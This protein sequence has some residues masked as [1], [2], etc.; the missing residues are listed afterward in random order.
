MLLLS[1]KNIQE[2]T[3]SHNESLN[4][5]VLQI[6]GNEKSILIF[7][8]LHHDFIEYNI[9][10]IGE[11]DIQLFL[12]DENSLCSKIVEDRVHDALGKVELLSEQDFTVFPEN[13]LIQYRSNHTGDRELKNISGDRIPLQQC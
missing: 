12:I 5:E 2:L 10:W 11:I 7:P 4:R 9:F 6:S 13:I 8:L 1:E 3:W